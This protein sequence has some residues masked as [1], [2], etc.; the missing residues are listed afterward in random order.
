MT[1]LAVIVLPAMPATRAS[2]AVSGNLHD[3][4][5]RRTPLS[6]PWHKR[7]HRDL[8]NIP[9][10]RVGGGG[11]WQLKLTFLNLCNTPPPH[12]HTLITTNYTVVMNYENSE[13][14]A[15]LL[16]LGQPCSCCTKQRPNTKRG[17]KF[18]GGRISSSNQKLLTIYVD[19]LI[20][21]RNFR[22]RSS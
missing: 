21:Q 1:L 12:T 16:L 11:L 15:S 19:E 22:L 10:C 7:R 3:H 14:P 4:S 5:R 2:R 9:K 20:I 17:D 8:S 18:Y 13:I 6:T